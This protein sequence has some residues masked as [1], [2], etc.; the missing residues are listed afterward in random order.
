MSLLLNK[1]SK[2]IIDLN[3]PEPFVNVINNTELNPIGWY[4]LP[5][6][7]WHH[8]EELLTGPSRLAAPPYR[9]VRL[10]ILS[11]RNRRQ[12]GTL[13]SPPGGAKGLRRI[14]YVKLCVYPC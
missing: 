8:L 6:G 12:C 5:Q 7:H 2:I 3:Y 14:L 11:T 10:D 4:P 9:S 13:S 1:Y